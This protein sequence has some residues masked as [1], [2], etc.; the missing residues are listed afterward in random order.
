M[1]ATEEDAAA[2]MDPDDISLWDHEEGIESREPGYRD[3]FH[4]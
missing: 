2:L 1:D 3:E 4:G